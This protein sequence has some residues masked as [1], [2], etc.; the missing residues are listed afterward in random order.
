MVSTPD[1]PATRTLRGNSLFVR[2]FQ[3]EVVDG[4]DRGATVAS[5]TDELTI[6]TAEGVDL[7]LSDTAVSRHHCVL[8]VAERGLEL[9][10]LGSTNGTFVGDT[11]LVRGFVSH[12]ARV[13]VGT[14]TI[15]VTILNDEL[16]QQLAAGDCFGELV[17]NSPAMR[18]L[19]PVLERCAN[20]NVTVLLEGET[21]TGKELVGESIHLASARRDGPFVVVDCG[22]LPRQL[23]ESELF[24]HVRGAF[25][26]AETD[27]VGAFEAASGGTIFLDEIGELALEL[28]P[29]LLRAL[30]SRK[31]RRVGTNQQREIDVRVIAASHRDL[32]FEVNAR[33]FR[34]DL[35][36]RLNVVRIVVPALADRGEDIP[37]LAKHFWRK[38][39]PDRAIPDEALAD[40]SRQ[41][42][43]GNVRELRNAVE[44]TALIGWESPSP[45]EAVAYGQAKERASREW[46]AR[47]VREL[48]AANGNN[49]AQA[50]R[51][52]QMSR[53]H[54][55][56][57]VQRYGLGRSGE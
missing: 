10:D 16:E 46:E 24:G 35:F 48:L 53:S 22:A 21:G 41:R 9:R 42:W 57:L 39:R 8:R 7:K 18:L 34:A 6:G 31:I 27:R 2:R 11:E 56:E 40:F 17:G 1:Q 13:R 55:R 37:L 26:G 30:E 43:P 4:V 38:Y 32:R 50:A 52:A 15:S 5:T 45:P 33:R 14:T 54:L 29:L 25:T 23:T 44:R 20:S 19:Y 3:V 28:Q 49:V 12:G 36:Y 51:A 47:W